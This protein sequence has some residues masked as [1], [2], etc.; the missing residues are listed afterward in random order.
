MKP[1]VRILTISNGRRTRQ[2]RRWFIGTI[3][4]GKEWF[5]GLIKFIFEPNQEN[6]VEKISTSIHQSRHRSQIRIILLDGLQTLQNSLYDIRQI[7]QRT[8]IPTIILERK[9][10]L[11]KINLDKKLQNLE[12]KSLEANSILNVEYKSFHLIYT[13]LNI[14]DIM[15]FIQFHLKDGTTPSILNSTREIANAYNLFKAKQKRPL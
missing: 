4:R 3:F 8:G 9:K 2:K 6:L 5:E 15:D 1:Q 7:Y 14:K 12:T 10:N 11:K 13:G